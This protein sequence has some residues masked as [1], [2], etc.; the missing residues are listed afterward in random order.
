MMMIYQLK[1]KKYLDDSIS[2]VSKTPTTLKFKEENTMK[3]PIEQLREEF[4]SRYNLT[5]DQVAIDI[6]LTEVSEG[7]AQQIGKD[8]GN[9]YNSL[10]NYF[11][12]LQVDA[13][14]N[15]QFNMY[16][17]HPEKEGEKNGFIIE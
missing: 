1:L 5:E 17:H 4:M 16:I 6:R 2:L 8:Y 12:G 10:D 13:V 9:K 15:K 14:S 7:L 11:P 3:S